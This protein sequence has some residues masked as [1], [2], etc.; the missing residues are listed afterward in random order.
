MKSVLERGPLLE[1]K[2]NYK[3]CN[4]INNLITLQ[5]SYANNAIGIEAK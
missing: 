5:T 2:F 3:L 1:D 4:Q